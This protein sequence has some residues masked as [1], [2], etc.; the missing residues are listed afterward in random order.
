MLVVHVRGGAVALAV[1]SLEDLRVLAA[2]AATAPEPVF[3]C[4][5]VPHPQP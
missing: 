4:M 2:Q 1:V 5:C 3:G